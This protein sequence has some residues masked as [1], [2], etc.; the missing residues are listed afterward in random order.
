MSQR[1]INYL[2]RKNIIY[3]RDPTTDKPTQVF[4]WGYYYENGTYQC[5]DLFKSKAKINTYRS[6]KWHL[7][8]LWYLNPEFN[9]NDFENLCK[10]IVDIKNE[11][12]TFTVSASSLDKIMYEVSM[13]D[14]EK[15]PNNKLRKV[16]FKDQT[17]LTITEK[18]KIV[19]SIIGKSK[20]IH[21]D[22]IYLC[23]LDINELGEKI[24]IS[25]LAQVLKCSSRTIHRNI[26]NELKKE[27]EL[28][29]KQNEKV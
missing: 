23:M 27:K 8:V 12:I 24:T 4:N 28:L 2:N 1:K 22:D 26:G 20:K 19:G 29:N 5:Y 14:L 21:K 7:L 25:K 16:I 3:R 18:L 15:P 11:F 10:F 17:G 13:C 9:E 6:L